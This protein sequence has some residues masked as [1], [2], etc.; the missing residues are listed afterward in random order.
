MCFVKIAG[1]LRQL[2]PRNMREGE[3]G[4]GDAGEACVAALDVHPAA[5][6][7]SVHRFDSACLVLT[8]CWCCHL[9]RRSSMQPETNRSAS[10]SPRTPRSRVTHVVFPVAGLGTSFLPAT[11]ACP[12]EMLPI[13][14]RP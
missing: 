13:V 14:D 4:P 11:K 2:L 12:K 1:S 8:P 5:A 6:V 7:E 9:A 10:S 3:S